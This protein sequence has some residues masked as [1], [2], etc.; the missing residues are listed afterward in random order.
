M[1]H[2]VLGMTMLP[3]CFGKI[4]EVV[5]YHCSQSLPVSLVYGCALKEMVRVNPVNSRLD[6]RCEL[7]AD[8]Q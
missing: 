2:D 8:P 1:M 4:K 3:R 6:E 5:L 7:L